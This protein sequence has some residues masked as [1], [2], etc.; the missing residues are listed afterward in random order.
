MRRPGP[1]HESITPLTA[2]DYVRVGTGVLMLILGVLIVVRGIPQ[3]GG[4]RALIVG[5]GLMV[6]GLARLLALAGYL[7][8]RRAR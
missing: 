2:A 7:K 6:V 1:V 4:I 5:G 3:G 8:G